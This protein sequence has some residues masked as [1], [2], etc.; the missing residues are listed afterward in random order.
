MKKY[1]PIP[2]PIKKLLI[3][4]GH[5][6]KIAR[7][8][9][10]LTMDLVAQRAFISRP[11]LS[12]VEQGDPTVSIDTYITVLYTLGLDKHLDSIADPS[13]DT[14]GLQIS[15]NELPQRARKRN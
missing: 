13:K 14:L 7:I 5:N 12:K 6:I 3:N 10:N 9:R 2:I 15:E 11:T 8:K 1:N 4:L